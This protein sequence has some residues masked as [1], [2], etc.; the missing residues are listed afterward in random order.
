MLWNNRIYSVVMNL[1]IFCLLRRETRSDEEKDD[2]ES[3]A[4]NWTGSRTIIF[5]N[6]RVPEK[7]ITAGCREHVIRY[8]DFV[9]THHGK[10][11]ELA[12]DTVVAERADKGL[13]GP[14]VFFLKSIRYSRL[15]TQ[16]LFALKIKT[17]F[18]GIDPGVV[19]FPLPIKDNR[20]AHLCNPRFVKGRLGRGFAP[21][22]GDSLSHGSC[23]KKSPT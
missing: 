13:V 12:L 8:C 5:N 21:G 23:Q 16:I 15:F 11:Q 1:T 9:F 22:E 18:A 19:G 6:R 3:Y 20:V 10:G 7:A 2:D 14:D 17:L 4:L